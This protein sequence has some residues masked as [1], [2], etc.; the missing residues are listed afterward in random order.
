[1]TIYRQT[2]YTRFL[3]GYI[4]TENKGCDSSVHAASASVNN[5]VAATH[6]FQASPYSARLSHDFAAATATTGLFIFM[7]AQ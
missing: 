7:L 6:E 1:M 3:S 4:Y 2:L 5:S